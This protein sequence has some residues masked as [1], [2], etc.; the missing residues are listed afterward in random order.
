MN[1]ETIHSE[2]S[3]RFCSARKIY[4]NHTGDTSAGQAAIPLSQASPG[5]GGGMVL[6]TCEVTLVEAAT[7]VL[8]GSYTT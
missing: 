8:A 2:F 5:T 6:E 4:E 7:D 1:C 3:Q